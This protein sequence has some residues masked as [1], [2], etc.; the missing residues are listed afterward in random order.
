M[1]IAA[2][3]DEWERNRPW[4]WKARDWVYKHVLIW[5]GFC[6]YCHEWRCGD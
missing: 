4:R 6:P 1:D 2:L 3:E 5:F